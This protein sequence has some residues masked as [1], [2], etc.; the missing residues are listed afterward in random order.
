MWCGNLSGLHS[1][2]VAQPGVEPG[3]SVWMNLPFP[4]HQLATVAGDA[5]GRASDP[6]GL[7]YL[8]CPS[9]STGKKDPE[10]KIHSR[11]SRICA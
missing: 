6:V 4:W 7:L 9:S 3:N 5:A 8:F 11:G 2:S 1:T 10:V